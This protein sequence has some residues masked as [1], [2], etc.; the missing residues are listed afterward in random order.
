MFDL[1]RK[2]PFAVI[3][4]FL[5][6]GIILGW[7]F[8]VYNFAIVWVLMCVLMF[9]AVSILFAKE[10]Q[11]IALLCLFSL[12]YGSLI[13]SSQ[14]RYPFFNKYDTVVFSVRK[15]INSEFMEKVPSKL[16]WTE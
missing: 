1:F 5:I 15:I 16:R 7:L 14:I 6:F 13:S 3:A 4:A 11:G 9:A 12:G 8:A 10:N 2:N